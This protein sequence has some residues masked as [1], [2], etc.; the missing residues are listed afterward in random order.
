MGDRSH[1]RGARLALGRAYWSQRD[2]RTGAILLAPFAASTAI[3][4]ATLT[5]QMRTRPANWRW[6]H[7]TEI[8]R[9]GCGR[10]FPARARRRWPRA[11]LRLSGRPGFTD[12]G[13][14][15]P[16]SGYA[17]LPVHRMLTPFVDAIRFVAEGRECPAGR[18]WDGDR[19][20]RRELRRILRKAWCRSRASAAARC[21]LK[22]ALRLNTTTIPST[23]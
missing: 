14:L 6:R 23:P 22:S 16:N 10:Q 21:Q 17:R 18:R 5:G 13:G 4:A 15:V 20:A 2:V 1:S 7:R 8:S 3:A 12:S 9:I 11:G 19:Y